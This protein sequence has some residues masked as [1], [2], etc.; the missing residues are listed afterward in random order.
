MNPD[1]LLAILGNFLSPSSAEAAAGPTFE[2]RQQ[3]EAQKLQQAIALAN[4]K[5]RIQAEQLAA[6]QLRQA[7]IEKAKATTAKTTAGIAPQRSIVDILGGGGTQQ[8]PE[9][10][11]IFAYGGGGAGLPMEQSNERIRMILDALRA[12]EA[13]SAYDP[14]LGPQVSKD[15]TPISPQPGQPFRLKGYE[16]EG[17][18]FDPTTGAFTNVGLPS[19]PSAPTTT[20]TPGKAESTTMTPQETQQMLEYASLL[21]KQGVPADIRKEA[22]ERQFPKVTA[23]KPVPID[24]LSKLFKYNPETNE[25][26]AAPGNLT[27]K[28]MIDEGYRTYDEKTRSKVG[29][30]SDVKLAFQQFKSAIADIANKSAIELKAS[31]LTGGNFG[32]PEGAIYK[33]DSINFTTIF[34][35]FLGGVRGAASPQ[36]QAIRSKVLPSII[37]TGKVS[38][39]L[40][41]DLESLIDTM[42]QERIKTAVG[43]NVAL[44][45]KTLNAKA[46]KVLASAGMAGPAPK[47]GVPSPT[48][49]QT[50]TLQPGRVP[51]RDPQGNPVQVK[52]SQVQKAITQG[53]TPWQ[54]Q[55]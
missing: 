27:E 18:G 28:Q 17:F 5:A 52:A 1:E 2:Q 43:A 35:K 6:D 8:L 47:T 16:Q 23:N 29:E 30:L 53:Y 46:E 34:D 20:P 49:P 11:S 9:G 32:G 51:M 45:T 26:I 40:M 15:F 41:S 19:M 42:S 50:T 4:E 44:D 48:Q 55:Q 25:F 14:L 37:S 22:I 3:L 21:E 36:M 10:S 54:P 7:N 13:P 31:E 24:K 33:K 12:G 39:R 38:D